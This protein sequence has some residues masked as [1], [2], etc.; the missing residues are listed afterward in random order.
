MKITRKQYE[1]ARLDLKAEYHQKLQEKLHALDLMWEQFGVREARNGKAAKSA[2]A[3]P[4]SLPLSHGNEV[5][6]SPHGYGSLKAEVSKAL[7]KVPNDFT[8]QH[9]YPEVKKAM[10]DVRLTSVNTALKKFASR[11]IIRLVE[12]GKGRWKPTR[13]SRKKKGQ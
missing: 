7:E 10:P 11:G 8:I 2:P 1:K 6:N 5:I 12:A 9:V 3:L 4:P 13:Y